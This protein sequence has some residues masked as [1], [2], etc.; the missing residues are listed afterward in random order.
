MKRRDKILI[1]TVSFLQTQ[2]T[3]ISPKIIKLN[4]VQT[5]H[6]DI[7]ARGMEVNERLMDSTY[8]VFLKSLAPSSSEDSWWCSSMLIVHA[9]SRKIETPKHK[10]TATK[11]SRS[12]NPLWK[13]YTILT[14]GGE[15]HLISKSA[16]SPSL[17]NGC[18]PSSGRFTGTSLKRKTVHK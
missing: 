3:W 6:T 18:T 16:T 9:A 13:Q 12:R 15:L 1:R 5:T 10:P 14:Y 4:A 7:S 8:M 11:K 2:E 17:D